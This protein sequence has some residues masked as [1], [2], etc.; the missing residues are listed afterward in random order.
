MTAAERM[1][2]FRKRRREGFCCLTIDFHESEIDALIQRGY[3]SHEERSSTNAIA[4]ALY[5]F[6]EA[7]LGIT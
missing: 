5:E 6:F 1:R 7:N 3:L 2:A 4:K